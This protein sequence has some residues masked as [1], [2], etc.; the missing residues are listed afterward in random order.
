MWRSQVRTGSHWNSSSMWRCDGIQRLEES[1]NK[2][3]YNLTTAITQFS[4]SKSIYFIW[5]AM[6]KL[7]LSY[8]KNAEI[9]IR[10]ILISYQDTDTDTDTDC[11]LTMRSRVLDGCTRQCVICCCQF[12]TTYSKG[13]SLFQYTHLHTQTQQ[14]IGATTVEICSSNSLW[15]RLHQ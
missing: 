7:T 5:W 8:L 14:T 9:N 4:H 15:G 2:L 11:T 12:L 6:S 10:I 13:N 3:G 1:H